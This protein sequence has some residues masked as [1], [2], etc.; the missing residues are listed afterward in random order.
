ML[1]PAPRMPSPRLLHGNRCLERP[2]PAR[3]QPDGSRHWFC[4]PDLE[5]MGRRM[6]CGAGTED[7]RSE[8]SRQLRRLE[9]SGASSEAC[10]AGTEQRSCLP[11]GAQ[12][13]SE[14]PPLLSLS[15]RKPLRIHH[16]CPSAPQPQEGSEN[17]PLLSLS[18]RSPGSP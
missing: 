14:N 7:G 9:V 8:I 2:R 3:D 17:P 1:T 16:R 18:H 6:K 10:P 15:P 11:D 12:E 13:A 4:W 5:G